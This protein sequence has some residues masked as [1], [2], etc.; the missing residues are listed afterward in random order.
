MRPDVEESRSN[1]GVVFHA[2]EKKVGCSDQVL[3]G[4]MIRPSLDGLDA[5]TESGHT[6]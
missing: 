4:G 5:L 1:S 3:M 6:D 2:N